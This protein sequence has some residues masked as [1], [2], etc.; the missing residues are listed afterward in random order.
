MRSTLRDQYVVRKQLPNRRAN[1]CQKAPHRSRLETNGYQSSRARC[2]NWNHPRCKMHQILLEAR[3]VEPCRVW[4]KKLQYLVII[5]I[6]LKNFV[7]PLQT[8]QRTD[9][10][11]NDKEQAIRRL[12]ARELRARGMIQE[13]PRWANNCQLKEILGVWGNLDIA[14]PFLRLSNLHEVV[15]KYA[16]TREKCVCRSNFT[17]TCPAHLCRRCCPGCPA[18]P[19]L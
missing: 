6:D 2:G 4:R 5:L 19:G 16:E 17:T 13:D 7:K 15:F 9:L 3:R 8:D 10:I 14:L 1:Q 11:E 12:V 18:H